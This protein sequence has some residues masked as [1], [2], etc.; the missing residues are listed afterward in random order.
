[1]FSMLSQL[2]W[3]CHC[4]LTQ[5]HQKVGHNNSKIRVASPR[6]C[7]KR[8]WKCRPPLSFSNGTGEIRMKVVFSLPFTK[9]PLR[10]TAER[11]QS[12]TRSGKILCRKG[13]EQSYSKT[14]MQRDT[15]VYNSSRKQLMRG[16]LWR[17]KNISLQLFPRFPQIL[18]TWV[19]S[20]FWFPGIL[21]S[22]RPLGFLYF[23]CL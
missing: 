7:R 21:C 2:I 4:Y 13:S 22:T 9:W 19:A 20:T 6:L 8:Q 10:G 17:N 16:L 15:E 5:W 12:N 23:F 3:Q 1:M 18:F 14:G 11:R